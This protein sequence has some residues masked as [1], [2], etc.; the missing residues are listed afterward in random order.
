MFSF[1][2]FVYK[3]K[4]KNVDPTETTRRVAQEI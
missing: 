2:K 4:K 3:K 1:I